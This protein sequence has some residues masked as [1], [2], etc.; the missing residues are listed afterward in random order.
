[1]GA[2]C[3]QSRLA[4]WT[5]GSVGRSCR[6]SWPGPCGRGGFR[7]GQSE[8][9]HGAADGRRGATSPGLTHSVLRFVPRVRCW[10]S[11]GLAVPAEEHQGMRGDP[12]CP[13]GRLLQQEQAWRGVRCCL[14]LQGP[15]DQVDVG[16]C[17]DR[18]RHRVGEHLGRCL[19]KLGIPGGVVFLFGQE[20]ALRSR[21]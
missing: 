2:V 20:P 21:H 4:S 14:G 16:P 9:T 6:G 18:R 19:R 5:V 12:G 8:E 10:S 13:L 17:R 11:K 15:G 3:S 7:G 1:M